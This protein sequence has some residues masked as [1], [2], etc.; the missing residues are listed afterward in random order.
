MAGAGHGDEH[1]D[2]HDEDKHEQKD[3]EHA[4]S[5]DVGNDEDR[6]PVPA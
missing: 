5:P 1:D 4:D 2:E 3:G 6:V